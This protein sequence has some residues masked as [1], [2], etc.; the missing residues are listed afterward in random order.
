[1]S[2]PASSI[3]EGQSLGMEDADQH[4]DKR[5]KMEETDATDVVM[6]EDSKTRATNHERD[7]KVEPKDDESKGEDLVKLDQRRNV[8]ESMRAE[9]E[10]VHKDMGDAFLLCRS[11]KTLHERLSVLE[12]Y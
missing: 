7:Q 12:V 11:S 6:E 1:M 8:S 4:R 10:Q 9:L 2:T 3:V 5:V